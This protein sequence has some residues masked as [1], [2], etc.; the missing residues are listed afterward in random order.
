MTNKHTTYDTSKW[1][2]FPNK[3]VMNFESLLLK[4]VIPHDIFSLYTTNWNVIT[5]ELCYNCIQICRQ[6]TA[7]YQGGRHTGY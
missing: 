3:M 7:Q 1:P 4:K 6:G 5:D 2:L